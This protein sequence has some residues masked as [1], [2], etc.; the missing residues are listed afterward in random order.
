MRALTIILLAVLAFS[1]TYMTMATAEESGGS[2][3]ATTEVC[4]I[5]VWA[6]GN[7]AVSI[8]ADGRAY[9]FDP[10]SSDRVE[11]YLEEHPESRATVPLRDHS[12]L[13]PLARTIPQPRWCLEAQIER[14]RI[15]SAEVISVSAPAP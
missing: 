11:E 12:G 14:N 3:I 1:S 2:R 10:K 7:Q 15:I 13:R 5:I 8:E 9:L 6:S 4:G